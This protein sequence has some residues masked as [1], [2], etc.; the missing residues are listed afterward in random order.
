MRAYQ[1]KVIFLKNTGSELFDEAYFVI[2]CDENRRIF[3]HATM[4]SE[5]RRI[6]EENFEEKKRR[7]KI[8]SP[9]SI[10]SFLVGSL[11]SVLACVFIF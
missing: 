4:V 2:S 10:L 8:F 3:S 5:A 11:I 6:I 7:I 9:V 1:K